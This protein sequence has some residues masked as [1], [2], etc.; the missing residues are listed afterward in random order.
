MLLASHPKSNFFENVVLETADFVNFR[1]ILHFDSDLFARSFEFCNG[2]FYFGLGI[3]SE[4]D[5]DYYDI[6]EC[7]RIYRYRYYD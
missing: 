7:G 1:P 3:S 5:F 4:D 2:E 6:S